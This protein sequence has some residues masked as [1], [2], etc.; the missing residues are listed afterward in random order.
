MPVPRGAS[1][2]SD[3]LIDSERSTTLRSRIE[4]VQDGDRAAL[5]ELYAD[6]GARVYRTA[7]RFTRHSADAE[8]VTQDVF[9]K[10]PAA[11]AG[12]TGGSAS[13]PAWIRKVTVRN[14][15]MHLRAG[16]RRRE[17]SV[18]GVMGLMSRAD[19]AV[20]RLTLDAALTRLGA[21]YRAVFLLKEVEGYGHAEIAEL[22]DISVA[23]S[24]GTLH[25]PLQILPDLPLR[26]PTRTFSPLPYT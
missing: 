26:S 25:R 20:D 9:L 18:D 17:V 4:R 21:Q 1:A 10:L 23:S 5:G 2:Q 6:F 12:F 7:L 16:K 3:T 19:S 11:V 14:A 8:D 22:L 24:E 15:L 13:F